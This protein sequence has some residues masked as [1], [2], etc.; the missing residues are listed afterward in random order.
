ME[1][2]GWPKTRAMLG[3]HCGLHSHRKELRG[4]DSRDFRGKTSAPCF[5]MYFTLFDPWSRCGKGKRLDFFF[6]LSAEDL[7]F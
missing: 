4:D 6:H 3:D 5:S 1:R 7:K 2:K